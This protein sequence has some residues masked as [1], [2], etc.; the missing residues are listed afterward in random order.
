MGTI[1]MIIMGGLIGWVAGMIMGTDIPG[2]KLG[3]IIAGLLGAWL[4]S[5]LLGNWGPEIWNVHILPA[6]VGTI[7]LIAL[8]SIILN[9]MKKKNRR[10]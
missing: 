8:T 10:V 1:L 4:G 3:N 7:L 6:L 5:L 2:G 9:M